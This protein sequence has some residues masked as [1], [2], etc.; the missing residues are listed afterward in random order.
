[1]TRD[2]TGH[3]S[4]WSRPALE[5]FCRRAFLASP[6]DGVQAAKDDD[7]LDK[8]LVTETR[9]IDFVLV[10]TEPST[11]TDG[12]SISVSDIER[13]QMRHTFEDTLQRL[14]IVIEKEPFLEVEYLPL[15]QSNSIGTKYFVK[16]HA[17]FELLLE[18]AERTRM[19][20]PVAVNTF[21]EAKTHDWIISALSKIPC[22]KR[23]FFLDNKE[24]NNAGKRFFT[25][26]YQKA[27]R[28]RFEPFFTIRNGWGAAGNL[29]NTYHSY[30][31]ASER[32]R[33]VKQ[34]LARC[35]YIDVSSPNNKSRGIT[36][37]VGALGAS[38][39]HIQPIRSDRENAKST[40]LE[41]EDELETIKLLEN[42]FKFSHVS[43]RFRG[44]DNL[45]ANGAYD[46]AF[47][48]HEPLFKHTSPVAVPKHLRNTRMR[49][50]WH[51]AKF[52]NIFK[53]QP[54]MDIRSYFGE[55]I[56]FYFAWLGWY[57]SMLACPAVLGSFVMLY[58]LISLHW[59]IP[60]SDICNPRTLG[61][62]VM[63]PRPDRRRFWRLYETCSQTKF[64]YVFDNEASIAFACVMSLWS[65]LFLCFWERE[66]NQYQ[67][68]WDVHRMVEETEEIRPDYEKRV[69]KTK[70]NPVTQQNEPYVSWFR[71][72]FAKMRSVLLI[73]FMV[74]VYKS[75][76]ARLLCFNQI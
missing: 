22:V 9:P 35:P 2:A 33:L 52:T 37:L 60:S 64:T 59:D 36:A 66:Q 43:S 7:N 69:Q 68:Q 41:V 34:I 39:F 58:G 49:L 74:S 67:F 1:M 55:R 54:L 27:Y 14:G 15:V 10:Y 20:L 76:T 28:R 63:C 47:P 26:E 8:D 17:P 48:L 4:T 6:A 71:R 18:V 75:H 65:V 32:S 53:Q 44:I 46:C 30:F 12:G 42:V 23:L 31:S 3:S 70:Y 61:A 62:T 25:T 5:S 21:R 16:L 40:T 38:V 51:W 29:A 24:F 56:A 72:A 45:L 50:Y 11:S 73:L 19:K 13:N 57:I